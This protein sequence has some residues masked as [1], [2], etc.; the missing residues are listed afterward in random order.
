[1]HVQATIGRPYDPIG[2]YLLQEVPPWAENMS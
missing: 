1:M 2:I